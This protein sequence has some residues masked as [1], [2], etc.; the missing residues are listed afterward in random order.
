MLTVKYACGFNKRDLRHVREK[1]NFGK[2]NTKAYT[3]NE[4]AS[5][6]IIYYN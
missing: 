2:L 6:V 3:L 4:L 5:S 1:I